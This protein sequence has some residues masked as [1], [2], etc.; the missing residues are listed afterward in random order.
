M[1]SIKLIKKP[2]IKQITIKLIVCLVAKIV[3]NAV[4]N[5]IKIKTKVIIIKKVNNF[6]VKR[7]FIFL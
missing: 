6:I 4:I 2:T 7:S 1:V 3:T 5:V